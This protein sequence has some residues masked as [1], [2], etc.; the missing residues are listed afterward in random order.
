[1]SVAILIFSLPVTVHTI[2][3]F[4][5]LTCVELKAPLLWLRI[6]SQFAL[7]RCPFD[8][9]ETDNPT[10]VFANGKMSVKTATPLPGGWSENP[11]TPVNLFSHRNIRLSLEIVFFFLNLEK[12]V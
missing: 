6:V 5:Y 7:F 11:R 3:I 12:D 1:M 10:V 4:A 9:A 2:C 8:S